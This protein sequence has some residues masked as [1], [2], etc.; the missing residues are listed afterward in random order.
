MPA[1]SQTQGILDQAGLGRHEG[2]DV[3]DDQPPG[4]SHWGSVRCSRLLTRAATPR[5]PAFLSLGAC[6]WPKLAQWL[7]PDRVRKQMSGGSAAPGLSRGWWVE[8]RG[9]GTQASLIRPTRSRSHSSQKLHW[10]PPPSKDL[11]TDNVP[12]GSPALTDPTSQRGA[13][14]LIHKQNDGSVITLARDGR[15]GPRGEGAGHGS[16]GTLFLGRGMGSTHMAG[17]Y[18]Y[19]VPLTFTSNSVFKGERIETFK[20]AARERGILPGTRPAHLR[21]SSPRG[22]SW[23][24]PSELGPVGPHGEAAGTGVLLRERT[25]SPRQHKMLHLA[26]ESGPS[27]CGRSSP[28]APPREAAA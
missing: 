21:I 8:Y 10:A 22:R 11:R 27:S 28:R 23:Y 26:L 2:R 24:C 25:R 15:T 20:P 4:S 18:V 16:L 1:Q 6:L 3:P 5:S 12:K 14:D 13:R 9:P 17:T 7:C 19:S